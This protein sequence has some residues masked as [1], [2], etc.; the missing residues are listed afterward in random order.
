MARAVPGWRGKVEGGRL[1][2]YDQQGFVRYRNGFEGSE[3]MVVVDKYRKQ[4]SAGQNRYYWGVVIPAMA[5]YCGYG[6]EEMHEALKWQLL[7]THAEAGLPSVRSTSNLNTAEFTDYI[8][9][10]RRLAAE[11]GVYIPDP[12]ETRQ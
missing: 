2:L 4:R 6:R 10:C 8:E 12:G 11:W 7:R 5:E 1:L 9:Q 3:V